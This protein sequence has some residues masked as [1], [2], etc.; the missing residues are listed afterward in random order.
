MAKHFNAL[1]DALKRVAEIVVECGSLIAAELEGRP[2][3]SDGGDVRSTML[4]SSSDL[5]ET[6]SDVSTTQPYPPLDLER[7]TAVDTRTA[8]AH[9]GRKPQTLRVWAFRKN[10]PIRPMRINGRLSWLVQ[11]LRKVLGVK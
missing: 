4:A 2:H 11:D 10:G 1:A 5:T 3:E 9:L 7:R 8:A 6:K